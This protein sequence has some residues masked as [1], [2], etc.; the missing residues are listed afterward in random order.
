MVLPTKSA[1]EQLRFHSR[2]PERK[3]IKIFNHAVF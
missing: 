1:D 2:H 3:E